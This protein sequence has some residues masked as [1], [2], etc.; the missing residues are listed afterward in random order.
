M[1]GCM[2]L[3]IGGTYESAVDSLKRTYW[4]PTRIWV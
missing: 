3:S 4:T 2:A 1:S